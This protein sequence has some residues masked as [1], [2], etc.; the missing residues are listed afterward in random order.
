MILSAQQHLATSGE[1]GA[2]QLDYTER[3]MILKELF[4]NLDYELANTIFQEALT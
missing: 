1:N 4:V 3:G 2:Q